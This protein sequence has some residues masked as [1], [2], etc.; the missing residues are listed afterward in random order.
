MKNIFLAMMVSVI[1]VSACSG[2]GKKEDA[3][4]TTKT[5]SG[6][7]MKPGDRTSDGGH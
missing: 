5:T 3:N 2:S 7:A 6:P 1:L 4:D